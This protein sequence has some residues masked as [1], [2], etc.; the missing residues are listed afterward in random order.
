MPGFGGHLKVLQKFTKREGKGRD[1]TGGEGRG[2]SE[3]ICWGKKELP[4]S[5]ANNSQ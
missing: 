2:E 1:R 4:N 3:Q 5:R